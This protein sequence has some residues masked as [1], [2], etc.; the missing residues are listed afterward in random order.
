MAELRLGDAFGGGQLQRVREDNHAHSKQ[1][2]AM[3]AAPVKSTMP[4]AAPLAITRCRGTAI[5]A[6]RSPTHG[7]ALGRAKLTVQPIHLGRFGTIARGSD[8]Q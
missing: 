3:A 1:M 4:V 2:T 5:I 6:S 8:L 7:I